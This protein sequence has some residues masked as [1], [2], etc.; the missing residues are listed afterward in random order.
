MAGLG[1][2]QSESLTASSTPTGISGTVTDQSN[3]GLSGIC[4][5]VDPAGSTSGTGG[6]ATTGPGGTYTVSGLKAGTY[7]VEFVPGCGNAGNFLEQWYKGQSSETTTTPVVVSVG[8]VRTGM[9]KAAAGWDHHGQ[10]DERD[11]RR[12]VSNPSPGRG[13]ATWLRICDDLG[14]RHLYDHRARSR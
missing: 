2:R 5:Q 7:D 1:R 14:K 12:A 8:A 13:Q 3:L 11:R 10:G 6:G 4:V 9:A